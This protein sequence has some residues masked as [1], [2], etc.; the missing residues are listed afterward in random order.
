[1]E[2]YHRAMKTLA[3]PLFIA[4]SS[5]ARR[6]LT[7]AILIARKPAGFVR[8]DATDETKVA[9]PAN[10]GAEAAVSSAARWIEQSLAR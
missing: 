9:E 8:S 3:L 4:A 1:M 10:S 6:S 7:D 5:V 2:F